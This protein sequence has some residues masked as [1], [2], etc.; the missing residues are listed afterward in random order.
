MTDPRIDQD[1]ARALHLQQAGKLAESLKLCM[2]LSRRAPRDHRPMR[3]AGHLLF[4]QGQLEPACKALGLALSLA[5]RAP[6]LEGELGACLL[7]G[8]LP[9]RALPHL[10]RAAEAQPEL[11]RVQAHRALA[12]RALRRMDEALPHLER[13][14]V[15]APELPELHA[16]LASTLESLGRNEE[17][18]AAARRALQL[19]PGQ[20]LARLVLAQLAREAGELETAR[21]LIEALLADALPPH[22]R[23]WALIEHGKLLDRLGEHTQAFA[24]LAEGKAMAGQLPAAR[25]VDREH[26]PAL[27]ERLAKQDRQPGEGASPEAP[28][29]LLDATPC[30]AF[31]LGFP[32][33]GTTLME[34]VL[35]AHP[36]VRSIDE[37]E[38]L[39]ETLRALPRSIGRSM[40][41]PEQLHSLDLEE[42]IILRK[43]YHRRLMDHLGPLE[44]E[45]PQRVVDKMPLNLVHTSFI[46]ALFPEAPLLVM[47]R[48]PRDCAL[49][50]FMQSFVP[51][52]AMIHFDSI[53]GSAALYA[54]VM[55]CWLAARDRPGTRALEIH[56]EELV[57]DLEAQARRA[58]EHLG[59]P[60]DDAV[61]RYREG[62]AGRFI[63]TPSRQDVARPIFTRARGRWRRYQA[64]L[65]PVLLVLA[66][67]V[68]ALGYPV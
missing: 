20:R 64:E 68:R 26:F 47:L 45:A 59:L 30:P 67:Y 35:L 24:S 33:S 60:W 40:A 25:R 23:A 4:A 15:L 51:T 7:A 18:E 38:I 9:E 17:A 53:Q 1:L 55:D 50:G 42:R 28:Q 32:R 27:L 52:V 21:P 66:P 61:L 46:R 12:L 44:G 39:G 29:A 31:L 62:V 41:Y 49:S 16:N 14:L 57:D 6:E 37:E 5:P 56:Y 8:G 3:L 2:A 65:E 54:R 36:G 10:E 11:A 63:S 19:D 48:D 34:Q 43:D 58:V 13:A 22:E